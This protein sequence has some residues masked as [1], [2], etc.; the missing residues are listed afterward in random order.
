[1]FARQQIAAV[2]GQRSLKLL[3]TALAALLLS[4]V[5]HATPISGRGTSQLLNSKELGNPGFTSN[6]AKVGLQLV[7][8]DTASLNH[9]N[10]G[11][12]MGTSNA[13]CVIAS[14]CSPV[15]VPEPQSLVLVGTGLLSMAGLIR[16]R[17]T[18]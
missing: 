16:R 14:S 1:M 5:I 13:T 15:A 18:R 12:L 6:T 7:A 9:L 10:D 8:A 3:T 2:A 11:I 4:G 17:L